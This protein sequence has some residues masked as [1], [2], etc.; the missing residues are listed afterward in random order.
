MI[1][2]LDLSENIF[3]FR[4]VDKVCRVLAIWFESWFWKYFRQSNGTNKW[5]KGV[6]MFLN[7]CWVWV[8][9]ILFFLSC[10]CVKFYPKKNKRKEG[11]RG[12]RREIIIINIHLAFYVLETFYKV[13]FCNIF[14]FN[15]MYLFLKS[16]L[17][18]WDSFA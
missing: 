14:K 12:G 8:L 10:S 13:Q 5:N 1:I 17:S 3:S 11:R 15:S 6:K 9:G 16:Y 7:Y 18:T 4:E 2:A